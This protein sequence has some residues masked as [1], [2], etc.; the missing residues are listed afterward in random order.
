MTIKSDANKMTDSEF[1][2]AY[3]KS[4]KQALAEIGETQHL[5]GPGTQKGTKSV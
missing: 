3:K 2:A 4:K 5:T 1:R